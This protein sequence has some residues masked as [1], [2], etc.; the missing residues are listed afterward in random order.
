MLHIETSSYNTIT[1]K[2][3][4]RLVMLP[5]VHRVKVFHSLAEVGQVLDD[6]GDEG[7]GAGGTLGGVLLREVE[8]RRRHDGGTHEAQEQRGADEGVGEVLPASLGAAHSPR[9]KHLL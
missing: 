3:K 6:L 1:V 4:V 7:E 8:Q 5:Q 9:R 2:N